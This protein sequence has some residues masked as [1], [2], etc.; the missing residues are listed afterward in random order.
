[1]ATATTTMVQTDWMDGYR[2][3][4]VTGTETCQVCGIDTMRPKIILDPDGG[5]AVY[6]KR[7]TPRVHRMGSVDVAKNSFANFT[8]DH[9]RDEFGKKVTVQSIAELRAA[10]KRYN[11]ALAV[12]ADDGGGAAAPPQHE[13]WAG[14]ISHD[15][16]RKFNR[17]P[18]AYKSSAATAGVSA[19]IAASPKDTL[20]DHPNPV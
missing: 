14:D 3:G 12:A 7:C 8:L 2:R 1:M 5:R 10:E 16:Q 18:K 15:Y 13:S 17:D 19:G 11:F 9:V 6:C 4:D 20:V